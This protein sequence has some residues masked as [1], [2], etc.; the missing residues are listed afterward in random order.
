MKIDPKK[1]DDLSKFLI[2]LTKDEKS[3]D[4]TAIDNLINILKQ[5]KIEARK[6]HCLFMHIFSQKGF[7]KKLEKKF[8]T[9]CLTEAPLNQIRIL[10]ADF[11]SRKIK[12][13]P[14]GLVFWKEDL[15]KKGASPAIYINA[16]KGTELRNYL[17][18]EFKKKFPSTFKKLEQKEEYPNEIIQY[19][20]LINKIGPN[21]DFSWEREWRFHG[22]LEFKYRDVVAIIAEYPNRFEKRCQKEFKRRQLN[23]IKKIPIINPN[24]NYEEVVEE[25]S[26][27]IWEK[28]K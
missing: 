7:S 24:W 6:A 4:P 11:P 10:S 8:N 25:M 1:R 3:G 15:L 9:V 28:E 18:K 20:S 5:K 22:D 23:S 12:L 19:F 26:R 21:Y 14:Y 13:K 2:H 27:R 17:L 16:E